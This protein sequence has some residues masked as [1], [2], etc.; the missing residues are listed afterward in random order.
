MMETEKNDDIK[1]VFEGTNNS[2]T[3]N[4]GCAC[5]CNDTGAGLAGG[6]VNVS[7]L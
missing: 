6:Q 3:S 4:S 1:V 7:A 2:T 5:G